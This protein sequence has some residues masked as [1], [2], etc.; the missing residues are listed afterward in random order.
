MITSSNTENLKQHIFQ[1]N[2][3]IIFGDIKIKEKTV[4]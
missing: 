2:G 4:Y 1:Y 3:N